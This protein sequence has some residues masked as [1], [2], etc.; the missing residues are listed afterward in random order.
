VIWGA[1]HGA[2]LCVERFCRDLLQRAH[3]RVPLS[4]VLSRVV[5]FHVV[6]LGWLFFRADSLQ[7]A[8]QLLVRLATAHGPAPAVTPGV[9]LA[10]AAGIGVQYIPRD[11]VARIQI[12]VSRLAPALQG[13]GLAAS[14]LLIGGLGPEGVA[15]FIYFRF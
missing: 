12:G 11:A 2:G 1:I 9:L 3:L 15:P 6:C 14:L 13:V 4:G 7:T 8:W 5:T 10:I